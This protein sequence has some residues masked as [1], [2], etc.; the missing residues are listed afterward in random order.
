MQT[1][2]D[3]VD[4]GIEISIGDVTAP[5]ELIDIPNDYEEDSSRGNSHDVQLV[6]EEQGVAIPT[7]DR[8]P[9][10]WLADFYVD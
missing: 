10:R 1:T 8:R 4:C 6:T 5:N 3:T 9:P 2:R 7:R